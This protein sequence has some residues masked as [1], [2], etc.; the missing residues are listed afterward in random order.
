M[1]CSKRGGS[2]GADHRLG[3]G[4]DL[5]VDALVVVPPADRLD[6]GAQVD[7]LEIHHLGPLLQPLCVEQLGDEVAEPARLANHARD[8]GGIGRRRWV[9]RDPPLEQLGLAEDH[10]ERRAQVVRGRRQELLLQTCRLLPSAQVVRDGG[11]RAGLEQ[12]RGVRRHQLEQPKVVLDEDRRTIGI[13]RQDTDPTLVGG[14]R[15]GDDRRGEVPLVDGGM[16]RIGLGSIERDHPALL[17]ER[18]PGD[19]CVVG[20]LDPLALSI[21]VAQDRAPGDRQADRRARRRRTPRPPRSGS[22]P[23]RGAHR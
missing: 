7:L 18:G 13:D 15:R 4:G 14:D 1:T 12:Q 9:A 3:R 22:R 20:V 16:L 21:H 8:A 11:V 17:A 19:E 6:D 10:G 5:E 23:R 2:I